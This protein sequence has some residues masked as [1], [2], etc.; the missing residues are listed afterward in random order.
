MGRI[1]VVV[2]GPQHRGMDTTVSTLVENTPAA[3]DRHVDG[4]RAFA[5]VVV[6][7][8]HWVFSVTHW[9]AHGSLT[10]PNPLEQIPG[11]WVLTW[12]LQVMPL[13]FVVGGYANRAAFVSNPEGFVR[14]RVGRLLKPTLV[15]LGVWVALDG[16][17][18]LV[19]PQTRSVLDW[20]LVIFVPLWFVG[21]YLVVGVLTPVTARLHDRFGVWVLVA[22]GALI[23]ANDVARFGFG[24][25]AQASPASLL[26]FVFAHQ[27]GYFWRDRA[28][29]GS[30]AVPALIAAGAALVLLVL[31]SVDP[32][33]RSMVS[34]PGFSHMYPTTACIAVLAI[35]QLGVAELL[36]PWCERWWARRAVWRWVIVVNGRAMTILVWHMTA[37][38]VAFGAVALTGGHLLAEPTARWWMERP[39]WLAGPLVALVVLVRAFGGYELRLRAG[40]AGPNPSTRPGAGR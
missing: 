8:W 21:V 16:F 31:T 9:S 2:L 37:W 19:L 32:Y 26:V 11:A 13:F 3:R 33:I 6:V 22:L 15:F 10:M 7:L 5:V 4:L 39:L 23:A 35:F 29:R 18:M 36:R 34:L 27:L 17:R 14:R 30:R 24:A 12:F 20:G 1:P 38:L 28:L 25:T 40:T